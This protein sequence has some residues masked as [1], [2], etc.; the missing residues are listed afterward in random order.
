MTPDKQQLL[1]DARKLSKSDPKLFR[2]TKLLLYT[3]QERRY[4]ERWGL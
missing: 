3:P 1:D 2:V 4:L